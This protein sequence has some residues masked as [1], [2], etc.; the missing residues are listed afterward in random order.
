MLGVARRAILGE[1]ACAWR[2]MLSG[3]TASRAE[4]EEAG[5]GRGKDVRVGVEG[6]GGTNG[7][8][9]EVGRARRG[10]VD[11]RGD[12]GGFACGHGFRAV[13]GVAGG[14]GYGGVFGRAAT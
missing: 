13:A 14:G 9:G 7:G 12:G 4:A 11:G 8:G 1:S 3:M 10:G 2:R 5:P 6:T